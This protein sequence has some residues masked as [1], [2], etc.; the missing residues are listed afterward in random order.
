MALQKITL[1]GSTKINSSLQVGD[2]IF[3]SEQS[4]AGGNILGQLLPVSGMPLVEITSG[5]ALIV[6]VDSGTTIPPNAY[7]L[8]AKPIQ[9]NES[10]VKGYYADLTLENNSKEKIELFAVSSET[11]LS[12]K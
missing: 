2:L 8:F 9:I 5:G 6:D 3:Y 7:I 1:Y 11:V 10:S 4:T 12:S